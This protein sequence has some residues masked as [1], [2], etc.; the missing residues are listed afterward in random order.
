MSNKEVK[1]IVSV[2]GS[3]AVAEF[4]KIAK[5][6]DKMGQ[7][8]GK[9]TT[10]GGK[11]IENVG[12][13]AGGL[14]AILGNLATKGLQLVVA[15]F[16]KSYEI[17][18]EFEQKMAEVGA[19]SGATG[20]ELQKMTDKAREVGKT[21]S[22]SASE[23]AD[24][25]KYMSQAGWTASESIDALEAVVKLSIATG[26][27]LARTS[28]MLTD[29]LTA[30]GWS[31][32]DA[33]KYADILATACSSS[34][35]NMETLSQTLKY[36]APIASGAGYSVQETV[37]A[38]MALGDAGIKGSQAGT[39]LRTVMLHLSGANK[40]AN[41]QLEKLGVQIR[42]NNG[43][44][45]PFNDI[46]GELSDKLVDSAG[47]VD[48]QT[49]TLLVGKNA[50]TGF[51]TLLRENKAGLEENT[52]ALKNSSGAVDEMASKM[53][54]TVQG[55]M[56]KFK[57]AMEDL[58]ITVYEG[59][60]PA[61]RE[62]ID[63]LTNIATAITDATKSFKHGSIVV[64]EETESQIGDILALGDE[65]NN[66]ITK[67]Q[68]LGNEAT[69]DMAN[70][71]IKS[72]GDMKDG[73]IA[74]IQE[75]YGEG[76]KETLAG[77]LR[78]AGVNED[79]IGI[80]LRQVD[81]Q[82]EQQV[83]KATELQEELNNL[84]KRYQDKNYTM[85]ASDYQRLQELTTEMSQ[86]AVNTLD[87]SNKDKIKIL[88]KYSKDGIKI[89]QEYGMEIIK[90]AKN[91]AVEAINIVDKE[92]TD[93][94]NAVRRAYEEGKINKEVYQDSVK[95]IEEGTKEAK[96]KAKAGWEGVVT[97][98]ETAIGGKIS[99][100]G[101]RE[102]DQ[103]ANEIDKGNKKAVK[104]V[105]DNPM[106]PK[107]DG[108]Q[109]YKDADT[110]ISTVK[111]KFSS[112][113][114]VITPTVNG[115]KLRGQLNDLNS[116]MFSTVSIPTLSTGLLPT[117]ATQLAGTTNSTNSQTINFNGSYQFANRSDIDYL[118]E[119]VAKRIQSNRY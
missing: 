94:L 107:V 118:M 8:L 82:K 13:K 110:V 62:G 67:Q 88:E 103:F 9:G 5:A 61:L 113:K 12:A 18:K 69:P 26:Y 47:N 41:K 102:I 79:Y 73:T 4:E 80:T 98:V 117:G 24:A 10:E 97:E 2:D 38:V 92:M 56:N 22:K 66:L 83:S 93:R 85:T 42:D 119:Q 53:E 64:S 105:K 112:A 35:V 39:T 32:K 70:K 115:S 99:G 27:D 89:S 63:L 71:V 6:S 45:R 7:D 81:Y 86:L 48:L 58:G 29:N 49:A 37:S 16:K 87:S 74:R 108:S 36:V 68:I 20:D 51:T 14:N 15:G 60:K 17:G 21:T 76:Y 31:S 57:S 30:F 65:I 116:G 44:M 40:E 77:T 34:N 72:Y 59:M 11:G 1:V 114:V 109:A 19:I 33:G 46:I 75:T 3:K 104:D 84:L 91:K 106:K 50:V 54:D 28:D 43:Q 90:D 23:S 101:K 52:N 55:S 111:G 95:A 96:N 100:E 25:L 78:M